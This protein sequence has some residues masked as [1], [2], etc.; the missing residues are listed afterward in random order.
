VK[1]VDDRELVSL[2]FQ[3]IQAICVDREKVV[4][5]Y[6]EYPEHLLLSDIIELDAEHRYIKY[7]MNDDKGRVLS[8]RKPQFTSSPQPPDSVENWLVSGWECYANKVEHKDVDEN[9]NEK[10]EDSSKRV[11]TFNDWVKQREIWETEQNHLMK[12]DRIFKRIYQINNDFRRDAEENE[13]LFTF[14]IFK[15]NRTHGSSVNHPLFTKRL[16]ID[17]EDI[18]KN[19]I[20]IY[21]TAEDLKFDSTCLSA[22]TDTNFNNIGEIDAKVK[23]EDFAIY[24]KFEVE[25]FLKSV[26]NLL[27]HS[28][29][30]LDDNKQ[31]ITQ[32]FTI[33]YSPLFVVRT[34]KSGIADFINKIQDALSDGMDIPQYLIDILNPKNQNNDEEVTALTTYD[35]SIEKRLAAVSGEDPDIYMT[36]PANKEQLRIAQEIETNAAVEVQGPPGTGK[37]H[38]IANLIGHF[39]AQ[40]KTVLVTSEKVK[41]L[42]VLKDKLDDEI[43]PLCVPVFDDNQGE[44]ENSVN[45][46]MGKVHVLNV[47]DLKRKIEECRK[48]RQ[49]IIDHLNKERK[50]I[51]EI[52]NKEAKD[53]VYEGKS[54]SVLDIAD[55]LAKNN[56][57]QKYISGKVNT[58]PDL[59]LT[60]EEFNDLYK[61]NQIL[62][63]AECQELALDL[64]PYDYLIS[65]EKFQELL[66]D[67]NTYNEHTEEIK[68]F[69]YS[70]Y[71]EDFENNQLIYKNEVLFEAP[72]SDELRK[73]QKI[74][75]TG[76]ILDDWQFSIIQDTILGQGYKARWE[77]LIERVEIFSNADSQYQVDLAGMSISIDDN[78]QQDELKKNISVIIEQLKKGKIGFF[79]K[80][81]HG[82]ASKVL[83]GIQINNH[84]LRT[85]DE[86][87]LILKKVNRDEAYDNLKNIWNDLFDHSSISDMN[88]IKENLVIYIR[89]VSDKI[90]QALQWEDKWYKVYAEGLLSSGFNKLL[91]KPRTEYIKNIKEYI[92]YITHN[93]KNY[94]HI[95][96][97]YNAKKQIHDEI[98]KT[99]DNFKSAKLKQSLNCNRLLQALL[100]HDGVAY[101]KSYGTY[102]QLYDKYPI[103]RN[104]CRLLLK[105]ALNAPEWASE[106][107]NREGFNNSTK[108]PCDLMKAWKI[109]QFNMIFY[110]VFSES[111]E[112][113]QRKVAEYSVDLRKKTADLANSLAWLHLKEHLA[114]KKEIQNNLAAWTALNK[115]I[116]KGTGKRVPEIRRQARK[117]MLQGQKAVP[118]WIIPVKKALETFD[119]VENHFDIAIVDE[120]SQSS[121]EALAITFLADKIIVVGD[122][123]QV[124]PMM[125][126]MDQN[127]TDD[128]L[129]KFLASYMNNWMLFNGTTSFYEIV[130]L[131]F[132]PL[133]LREHFRCVPEIIGYSNEKFYNN[134]ILPLRDSTSSKLLPP[135]INCR[136]D[137]F[138]N[139]RKKTNT[140]EAKTIVSL[141][142]ACWEQEEYRNKTFGVISMVGEDQAKIISNLILNKVGDYS[143][144]KDR[145]L[146][147]GNAASFQGDERDIIFLSMVD[148]NDSAKLVRVAN[149]AERYN[150]AVSRAKDQIWV[151]N[152]LDYTA[153]QKDDLKYGL[154]EYAQNYKTHRQ[155]AL[156]IERKSESQFEVEVAQF[157]TTTGYHIVQ[158]Y[159]VG[160]YRLDIVV[161]YQ[162]RKIAVECDGERFHSGEVK[163]QQDM[164]RQCILERLGWR[165]IRIPGGLFY[166]D[167]EDTM[168]DVYR[169]LGEYD[170]YPEIAENDAKEETSDLYE[171]V[172]RRARE[173]RKSWDDDVDEPADLP[174]NVQKH[175]IGANSIVASITGNSKDASSNGVNNS[176]HRQQTKSIQISMEHTKYAE[177]TTSNPGNGIMRTIVLDE[178]KGKK[179]GEKIMPTNIDSKQVGNTSNHIA[180]GM[181]I[182]HKIFGEGIVKSIDDGYVNVIFDDEKLRRFQVPQAFKLGF[183]KMKN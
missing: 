38:T 69:D 159:E 57:L 75:D 45:S 7:F 176:L 86:A 129:K 54:Y 161:I 130:G 131:S 21:D 174:I 163:I 79:F 126:G 61:S 47:K 88:H 171:R 42:T 14:G 95:A 81:T 116:G 133:M 67:I 92:S 179:K 164:E 49:E 107:E 170:I 181:V 56:D 142:M 74:L 70:D 72:N 149:I 23:N 172:V 6:T 132:Q 53:I 44:M 153:L 4:S 85:V 180:I 106:I 46:I 178:R 96:L 105:L 5:K 22:V 89:S 28:G 147:S 148:D 36:K 160:S 110:D 102:V 13:L 119:P 35:E 165:F 37:T 8:V 139:G 80:L 104:R 27:T 112:E 60:I 141:I 124:S 123:K 101:M 122:D 32:Q 135:V 103:Y 109:R 25:N 127:R 55:F 10:F 43:K 167:K 63:Q 87:T 3:A 83:K 1:K 168:K 152:S 65:P 100:N 17:D 114:G 24:D 113:R 84:E 77:K 66:Q 90:K 125:V 136:V 128:I 150:V 41:A 20:T 177:K 144:I 162:N 11:Q 2:L 59:P 30:Y 18:T 118:A 98:S 26:I 15:D 173:I 76:P 9:T 143:A 182:M 73:L 155:Q 50:T 82:D 31:T 157:L 52:R 166:R 145:E 183:L 175:L 138:R 78:L 51:F 58:G 62:S 140:V 68:D 117:C 146:I 120:A 111:L 169:Q 108:I 29:E 12:I 121:L 115:K 16:R 156:D 19:I 97:I 48:N 99:E 94:I 40:G 33:S 39:L 34:R 64:P 134:Q 137:G 154:L 151:V 158:Q 71:C 93:V 91:L